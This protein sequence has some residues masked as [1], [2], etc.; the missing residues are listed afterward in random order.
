M[1]SNVSETLLNPEDFGVAQITQ[2]DIYGG[3]TVKES[4]HIFSEILSGN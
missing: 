4:A 2:S 1:I 3:E